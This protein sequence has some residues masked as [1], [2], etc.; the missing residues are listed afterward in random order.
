MLGDF[1]DAGE[2]EIV[3]VEGIAPRWM[4]PFEQRNQR[5]SLH[6][7]GDV[8]TCDVE[9]GFRV[10]E[11]LDQ[12][13]VNGSRFCYAG[14]FDDQ[15][16]AE[17]FFVHPAFVIPAM[18][19][20]VESLIGGVD[21][22][23][24]FI[25]AG[26]LEVSQHATDVFID[27]F[28]TAEVVFHVALVFPADEI[29]TS[30]VCFSQRFVFGIEG[31]VPRCKL[32]G[33]HELQIAEAGLVKRF[34]G[35]GIPALQLGAEVIVDQ[36]HVIFDRH[37]RMTGG[38][39]VVFPVVEEG[40]R[41]GNGD[42]IVKMQVTECGHPGAVGCF[43]LA[44]EHEGF[45]G[46]GVL[47]E[48]VESHVGDDVGA[49]AFDAF[50]PLGGL[51]F[52]IVVVALPRQDLPEV[53]ALGIGGEVPLTDHGSLITGFLQE[54]GEGLLVAVKAVAVPHEAINVAVFAGED[55]GATGAADGVRAEAVFEE[56]PFRGNLVD[57]GSGVDLLEHSLISTDSVRRM[58]VGKEKQD[59]R[60]IRSMSQRRESKTT[61]QHERA[62]H[63]STY[64]LDRYQNYEGR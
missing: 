18:I 47:F 54:F 32:F 40:G 8:G 62:N 9:E 38:A 29:F 45:A 10:V 57:V 14:P 17:G 15:R 1:V 55:D 60:S 35:F 23:G 52:G 11:I 41:F 27:A 63:E 22:D 58:I 19:A 59:V 20:E 33:C 6:V 42:V 44:H 37:L 36:V 25:E 2:I 26:F 56:H 21:D 43:V 48:P 31:G 12:V 16:H 61:E 3:V 64:E 5:A 34:A 7:V 39:G 4:F 28:D 50:A 49:V 13:G 51:E 53:E 24:I 30:E 46:V